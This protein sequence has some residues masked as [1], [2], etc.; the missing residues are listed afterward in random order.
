MNNNLEVSQLACHLVWRQVPLPNYLH[1]P[2]CYQV[3][4]TKKEFPTL[5]I[6]EF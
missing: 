5:T 1:G 6:K 2:P 4:N 3:S